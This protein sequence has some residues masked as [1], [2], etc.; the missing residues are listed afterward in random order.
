[1]ATINTDMPIEERAIGAYLGL[2]IGDAL[3][4]TVEF[5]S[6]KDIAK[7]DGIHDEIIGGGWLKLKPGDVTDD[8]TMSLVL[9]DSILQQGCVDAAAVAEAFSQWLQRRPVDIGATV[10]RGIIHY[11]YSG[12]PS[13]IESEWDA[14]NGACMRTLPVALATLGC[15]EG[16][17]TQASRRQAHVTHNNSLS[18]VA[19]EC[20]IKLIQLAL[21]GNEKSTLIDYVNHELVERYPEFEYR[22]STTENPGGYIV[23]TLQAVLQALQTTGSFEQCLI[24]VVNRGGDADTTGAIAGMVAGSLYGVESIPKRWRTVLNEEI[25]NACE[26]QAV[27]LLQMDYQPGSASLSGGVVPRQEAANV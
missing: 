11:R 6:A 10:K 18:D 16:E 15:D 1:M 23:E 13:V 26:Q 27:A 24:N 8:T 7:R 25:S 20:V 12:E 9:G 21:K 3:G 4:A 2:A 19:T 17:I 22:N 5:R 14:G